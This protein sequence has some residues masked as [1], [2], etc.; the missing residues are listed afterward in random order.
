MHVEQRGDHWRGLALGAKGTCMGNL[1][2]RQLRLGAEFDPTLFGGFDAG[3][4][5]FGD[6][7]AF[8]FSQDANYLPHGAAGG[9]L[10]VTVL[11]QRAKRD[12]LGPQLVQQG[13][14]IA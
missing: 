6:Q 10:G 1:R 3:M 8:Q 12:T 9:G 5:A 2:R 7:T 13:K 4:G 14:E 11:S